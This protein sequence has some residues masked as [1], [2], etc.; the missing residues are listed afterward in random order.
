MICK[1]LKKLFKGKKESG[2]EGQ[3]VELKDHANKDLPLHYVKALEKLG[4]SEVSGSA[5]NS[6][7]VDMFRLAVGK[8]Y[9][10]DTAWCAAFVGACLVEVGLPSSGSLAA[11]SYLSHGDYAE[12]PKIGDIVVIWRES[13]R[14][15]KGHVGFFAGLEGGYIK[16]LGGNQSNKVSIAR[17]PKSRLLGYRRV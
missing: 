17:Y 8:E 13:P 6:K 10:D 4:I 15:W 5:S 12:E 3:E 16:I 7:I 14:S 2:A 11:R 1:I 9:P